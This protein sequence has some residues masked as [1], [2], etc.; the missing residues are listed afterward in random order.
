MAKKIRFIRRF[1]EGFSKRFGRA[2]RFLK[3]PGRWL[4]KFKTS[5]IA[6]GNWWRSRELKRLLIGIPGLMV[7]LGGVYVIFCDQTA[8]DTKRAEDYLKEGR[9]AYNREQWEVSKMLL[10]RAVD[11]GVDDPN[12]RFMLAKA[13]Q[14]NKDYPRMV[15]LLNELAPINS[16]V[17]GPAHVWQAVQV[18]GKGKVSKADARVAKKHLIHSIN[19]EPQNRTANA[20]L[21]D[22]YFQESD[23][24]SAAA[25]LEIARPYTARQNILLARSL[26]N[27]S[28]KEAAVLAAAKG[29]QLAIEETRAN[30]ESDATWLVLS[31]ALIMQ[32]KFQE[33]SEVI[34]KRIQPLEPAFTL[35]QQLANVFY[36]WSESI[37]EK[38]KENI[39]AVDYERFQLLARALKQSPQD[40]LIYDRMMAILLR[41]GDQSGQARKLLLRH[42]AEGVV[43]G[44]SHLMLGTVFQEEGKPK[45]AEF[46]LSQAMKIVPNAPIVLNNVAVHLAT[47]TP[48]RLDRALEIMN[49]VVQD[50]PEPAAFRETRGEILVQLKRFEEALVDLKIAL[51]S[52][53]DYKP[54]H[55]ALQ[56]VYVGL[57]IPDLAAEHGII[58]AGL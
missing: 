51:P 30:P 18:L 13:S 25:H 41:Q 34:A 57:G 47:R 27:T 46:H 48:P 16:A 22:L 6:F 37:A 31:D 11:L 24:E 2:S 33:A 54:I 14:E 8:S 45:E 35:R 12:T 49:R 1:N 40:L 4:T 7:L 52:Y 38:N 36:S 56:E 55:I 39:S 58:A 29:E 10:S 32:E 26:F 43:P 17:Y 20:L 3:V 50:H 28:R 15:A 21:G 19:L 42:I 5:V 23:W 44:V 9:K 53:R